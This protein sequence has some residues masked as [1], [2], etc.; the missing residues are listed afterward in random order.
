MNALVVAGR[1]PRR[2]LPAGARPA[3]TAGTW[4]EGVG[5]GRAEAAARGALDPLA[6]DASSVTLQNLHSNIMSHASNA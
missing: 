2:G 6:T 4:P 5:G 3:A 1:G